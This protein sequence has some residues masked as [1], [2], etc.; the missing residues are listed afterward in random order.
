MYIYILAGDY[1]EHR[2]RVE[3]VT[4]LLPVLTQYRVYLQTDHA[5]TSSVL[6]HLLNEL[7]NDRNV[8]MFTSFIHLDFINTYVNTYYLLCLKIIVTKNGSSLYLSDQKSN[9]FISSVFSKYLCLI[10]RKLV[11]RPADL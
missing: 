7:M 2:L 9:S 8:T 5:G 6:K 11:S 3:I 1:D 10:L 4:A